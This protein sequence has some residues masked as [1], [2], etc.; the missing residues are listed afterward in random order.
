MKI[1]KSS[2]L[3]GLLYL[4]L[5]M[6]FCAAP[7]NDDNSEKWNSIIKDL[8]IIL[9]SEIPDSIKAV[10]V[11]V[12]FDSNQITLTDYRKF[13]EESFEKNPLKNLNYLKEIEQLISEDMKIEARRQ[14][15]I[16]KEI[17]YRPGKKENLKK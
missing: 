14:K 9:A 5:L 2:I 1:F 12:L 8:E 7:E 16:G 6:L 17:D 11:K 10:K 3:S 4:F 15:K 13:Y